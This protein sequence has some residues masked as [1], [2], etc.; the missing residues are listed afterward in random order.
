MTSPTP[1]VAPSPFSGFRKRTQNLQQWLQGWLWILAHVRHVWAVV[2]HQLDP[3][4]RESVMIAVS[5]VNACRWCSYAHQTWGREVGLDEADVARL[6]DGEV[7]LS[8]SRQAAAVAY[9]QERAEAA[10]APVPEHL[11]VR[12]RTVFDE[13]DADRVEVVARLM[14][15]A[16]MAGNSVD[17]LLARWQGHPPHHS[18]LVDDLVIGGFGLLAILVAVPLVSIVWRRSPHR[19]SR[20]LLEFVRS[21]DGLSRASSPEAGAGGAGSDC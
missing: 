1:A 2:F 9:A 6:A 16:N 18:R 17:A 7:A 11:I 13:Q 12:L 19:V 14:H 21:Y 4:L 10:F 15:Q 20:E 3:A 5:E 8:D